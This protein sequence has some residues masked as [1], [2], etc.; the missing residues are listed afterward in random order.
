MK[1]FGISLDWFKSNKEKELDELKLTEQKL[2]ND[3]LNRKLGNLGQDR[4]FKSLKM[5]NDFMDV[6][7]KD[8]SVLSKSNAIIN[9]Y[10]SV[11]NANSEAQ[12]IALLSD[13]ANFAQKQKE[14][15]NIKKQEL[16]ANNFTLLQSIGNEFE[17]VGSSVYFKGIPRTVPPLLVEKLIE[18]AVVNGNNIV[19]NTE[20]QALKRFFMWCCLNPRAE[21]ADKLYD[22]LTR[23]SFRITKQGFFVA[24]RNV[25]T[26]EKDNELVKF[27][28]NA[29][30]K[31]KATWKKN[32]ADYYVH[33]DVENNSYYF[34]KTEFTE[35]NDKGNLKE[36]YLNL[37]NM[38][39]N[40]FTD[41]YTRTFDIRVGKVV[42]MPPEECSWST[43]DCAH[44]GLHFTA[45]E[46][47]YVGCGDTSVLVLINPMKVVGIGQSKGRCY[48]YLPIMTVPREESTTI[49]HDLDFDTLELDEDFAIRELDNLADKAKNGFSVEAKKY[50]FNIPTIS[51]NVINTIVASLDEMRATIKNRVEAVLD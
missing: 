11:R 4:P 50:D 26:V 12:V 42:N 14:V 46:I 35:N 51:A 37:P 9:D 41:D 15:E 16:I 2:K 29:Y 8:G 30:N 34:S 21:V 1:L 22:F 40:R 10:N 5:I 13:T 43:A 36:L 20:Y 39:E 25:V 45:D 7:L 24:L 28:S 18:L 32:P 17:V 19:N 48:E 27:V 44:A 31:I 49:L 47:N 3:I 33:Y 6:V 38:A 23:N